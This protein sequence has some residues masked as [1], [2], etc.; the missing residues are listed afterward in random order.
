[1]YR[2]ITATAFAALLV[3]ACSGGSEPGDSEAL[4]GAMPDSMRG[5]NHDSMPGMD[6][7][8]MPGM[9]HDTMSGAGG[10]GAMNHGAG[11]GGTGAMAGM[12]HSQMEMGGRSA[13]MQ[14]MD[15]SRMAASGETMAG[16]Q[17]G[18]MQGMQHGTMNMPA[19]QGMSRPA[20]AADLLGAG[21]GTEKLLT[22]VRELVRDPVVQQQ[23]QQDP[24]LRQAWADPGVREIILREP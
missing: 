20:S 10:A 11:R 19:E 5:M 8:D 15:H 7:A 3:G 17:H 2:L 14:G 12:D 9:Q 22:L 13:G 23:I 1:M 16:M 6:H 4:P 18:N 24:A 21:E